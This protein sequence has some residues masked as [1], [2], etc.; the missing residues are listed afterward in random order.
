VR[1]G[2]LV[3]L[4]ADR[5]LTE[6]GLFVRFCDRSAR[7]AA[8]PAALALATGA[9]LHPVAIYYEP[10]PGSAPG[11]SAYRL[12]I[13]FGPAVH[14]QDSAATR[15]EQTQDLTQ[16]CA[17]FLTEQVRAHTED[18]HMIQRV[19]VPAPEHRETVR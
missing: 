5:D 4:L 7:M 6:R 17:D 18:W 12:V 16:Q 11:P 1:E 19:F 3:P 8:G 9:P 10:D 15:A 2:A 13:E 14:P